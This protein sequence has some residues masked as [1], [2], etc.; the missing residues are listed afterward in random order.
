MGG[1]PQ[2]LHEGR[3]E[4][5]LQRQVFT[6]AVHRV[7]DTGVDDVAAREEGGPCGAADLG[8]ALIDNHVPVEL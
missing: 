3:P 2:V 7:V 5:E 8:Y 1:V 6:A 4:G